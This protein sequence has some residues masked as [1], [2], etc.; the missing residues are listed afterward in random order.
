MKSVR[1]LLED[2]NLSKV[3]KT[4]ETLSFEPKMNERVM[5]NLYFTTQW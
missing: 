5:N 2:W 1:W 4:C 3:E